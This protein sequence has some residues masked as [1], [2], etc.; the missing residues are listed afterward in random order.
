M[1][2]LRLRMR[3]NGQSPSRVTLEG[4]TWIESEE[5]YRRFP[6]DQN[7]PDGPSNCMC[8]VPRVTWL[9]DLEAWSIQ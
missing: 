3:T 5:V 9:P 8:Q 7:E 1:L 4:A 6:G 2:S